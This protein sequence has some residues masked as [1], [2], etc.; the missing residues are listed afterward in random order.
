MDKRRYFNTQCCVLHK[1]YWI[2]YNVLA[3]GAVTES[4]RWTHYVTWPRGL[5]L[6]M[7]LRLLVI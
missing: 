7:E 5:R 2:I 1:G 3:V 6:Q 4:H